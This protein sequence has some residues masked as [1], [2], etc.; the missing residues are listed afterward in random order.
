[1]FTFC[2]QGYHAKKLDGYC[3]GAGTG[4]SVEKITV[5]HFMLMY[6]YFHTFSFAMPASAQP[7]MPDL[8]EESSLASRCSWHFPGL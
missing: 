7:L 4:L 3:I 1:M 6:F 5:W 2:Q 8:K